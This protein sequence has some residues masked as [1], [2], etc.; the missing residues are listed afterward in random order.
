M[1]WVVRRRRR[2]RAVEA[3]AVEEVEPTATCCVDA[4][5]GFVGAD[6]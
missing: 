4:E 5:V 2:S 3:V 1:R 6:G